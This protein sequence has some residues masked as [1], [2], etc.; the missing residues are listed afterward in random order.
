MMGIPHRLPCVQ[1][2]LA[3]RASLTQNVCYVLLDAGEFARVEALGVIPRE[4]VGVY[5]R[6]RAGKTQVQSRLGC[7][8]ASSARADCTIFEIG[9]L[10]CQSVGGPFALLATSAP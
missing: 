5:L 7:R 2:R 3:C 1:L 6:A 8:L 9:Q 10:S 4:D